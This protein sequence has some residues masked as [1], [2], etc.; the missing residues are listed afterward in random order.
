MQR[1]EPRDIRDFQRQRLYAAERRVSEGGSWDSLVAAQHALDGL[2]PSPWWQMHFP[3]VRSVVLFDRG[4]TYPVAHKGVHGDAIEFPRG[5]RT[6]LT[7]FHELAHLASP[8]PTIGHG[9]VYAGIYLMLVQHG[10]GECVAARLASHF[11]ECHV[12]VHPYAGPRHHWFTPR[13]RG[14]ARQGLAAR[15][16]PATTA[17]RP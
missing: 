14:V 1:R 3:S 15:L 17:T 6:P 11:A 7:L 2:L 8:P 12:R 5:A 9:P 16:Q 10:R 4:G 13:R